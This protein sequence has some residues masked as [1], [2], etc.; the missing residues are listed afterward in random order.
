[1]DH[2]QPPIDDYITAMRVVGL[3][4]LLGLPEFAELDLDTIADVLRGF[5][6]LA[7]EI[8]T[9][10]DRNGDLT[11]ATLDAA[12]A[13]VHVAPEIGL[14]LKQYVEGGWQGISAASSDGG[15]GFPRVV[16]A[17]VHEMFGSANMALSLNPM[18]TQSAIELLEQ[19]ADERQ[20][21]IVLRR[22][23][24]GRWTGTMN[25]TEPDAGSDLGAVRATAAP[26]ADG[27]WSITGTK[28]FITWGEHDLAENIIHLVLARTPEAP[29]GTKGISVFLVPKFEFDDEG[30]IGRRNAVTCRSL[31]HKLGIHSSPTCVME[32]DGA[33][34]ELVGPLNGGMN[35][36]FSMMNPARLAVGIQG[37]SVSER[38][39]Q[40]ARSFAS[41][42]RQ[43]R[44]EGRSAT[45]P[46]IGHP[47]VQRMLVEMTAT[48]HSA[49]LLTYATAVAGDL[50]HRHPDEEQRS[51][52]RRRADLLTPLAKAWPTDRGERIAS[53]AVQIHGGM[54]FIEETGVAQRYRDVRIASIYEGTNGI[55]AIDL[56]AR[57]VVR[58]GGQAMS[59]LFEEVKSTIENA[60]SIK[61]V[62]RSVCLLDAALERTR[63]A[64]HW[65][66]DRF[67]SDRRSVLAGATA[68]LELASLVVAG[69]LLL[70]RVIFDLAVSSRAAT[71]A[72]G[73]F[74]YFVTHQLDQAPSIAS[75]SFDAT[76]LDTVL[77][78]VDTDYPTEEA[79][80]H[81][82]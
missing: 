66:L 74:N 15:G 52:H 16:G 78:G 13:S 2:F 32:F 75:I 42:R 61:E 5:G 46:I 3:D 4:D 76:I 28:I 6:S 80:V 24:S 51:R 10:T 12:T 35:V 82:S 25:L 63:T 53:L 31:E 79:E 56:V 7:S 33:V 47:D 38:S 14:A 48:T 8:I 72:M 40:Q 64:T 23:V 30:R 43:G 45:T 58:D 36:M 54:G 68:Y 29:A 77:E 55:Q 69:E 71:G 37:V 70:R 81:P 57:K 62:H 50:A 44:V 26:T 18:L 20:R 11:G 19:W 9:P 41:M 1:V 27:R 22:L 73:I 21:R 60:I 49:R 67:D 59:E 39:L 17:S 34:G 65:I